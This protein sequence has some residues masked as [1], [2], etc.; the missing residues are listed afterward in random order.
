MKIGSPEIYS[1]GNLACKFYSD[2]G[3]IDFPKQ[4]GCR[5]YLNTT[6]TIPNATFTKI[7]LNAKNY[8]AQNEFDSTTNYRFTATKAGVYKISATVDFSTFSDAGAFLLMFYKNGVEVSRKFSRSAS[9][10]EYGDTHTDTIY[11]SAGD[12]IELWVYQ[13]SGASRNVTYGSNITFMSIT[14]LS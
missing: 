13:N 5:V 9:T 10:A 1:N 3:I 6:Q 14:K 8:D 11:L 2:S 7:Q 12:Y 4:S